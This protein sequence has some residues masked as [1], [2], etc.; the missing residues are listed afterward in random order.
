MSYTLRFAKPSSKDSNLWIKSPS[1]A[2]T[3]V[4]KNW[5]KTHSI[6]V[7]PGKWKW[8]KTRV[9]A[10]RIFYEVNEVNRVIDILAVRP[11]QMAYKKKR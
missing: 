8:G 7:S 4:C 5:R 6:P 10:W 9:G 3:N 1:D 2:F 11:R